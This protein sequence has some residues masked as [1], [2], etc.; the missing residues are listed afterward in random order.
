MHVEEFPDK[1][2]DGIINVCTVFLLHDSYVLIIISRPIIII[3]LE[4]I[5][6]VKKLIK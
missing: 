6:R 3:I 1:Y 5:N 4:N 2:T